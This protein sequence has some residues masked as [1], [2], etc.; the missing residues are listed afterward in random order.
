MSAS[1][2]QFTGL[3]VCMYEATFDIVR[4]VCVY[5]LCTFL[6]YTAGSYVFVYSRFVLN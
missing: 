5:D 6:V 2:R 3:I 1:M 4:F